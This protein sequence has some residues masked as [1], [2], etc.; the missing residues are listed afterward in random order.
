MV[1]LPIGILQSFSLWYM[2]KLLNLMTF[3]NHFSIAINKILET[4]ELLSRFFTSN[5]LN[6]SL[7]SVSLIQFPLCV[8]LSFLCMFIEISSVCL[9]EFLLCVYL[10]FLCIFILISSVSLVWY[11]QYIQI[12]FPQ[13]LD[14][15]VL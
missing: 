4:M 10:N 15:H 1:I 11:P 7:S 2:L 13:H 9:F 6:F 12:R 8:Y 3:Y 5:F 14:F